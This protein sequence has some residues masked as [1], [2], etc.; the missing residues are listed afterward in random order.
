MRALPVSLCPCPGASGH[1]VLGLML[2][3]LAQPGSAWGHPCLQPAP[4]LL[5]LAI[6]LQGVLTPLLS[7]GKAALRAAASQLG[8][9][10]CA[11][12]PCLVLC[13]LEEM[14]EEP[15]SVSPLVWLCV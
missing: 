7:L 11:H 12:S 9:L 15:W 4:S 2:P 1:L 10:F 6:Q 8:G 13:W 5:R 14:R 3:V